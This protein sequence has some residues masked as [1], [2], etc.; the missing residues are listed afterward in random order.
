[1]VNA[2]D[3]RLPPPAPEGGYWYSR[4]LFERAL[5]LRPGLQRVQERVRAL[6]GP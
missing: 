2:A 5:A 4:W 3:D 1:M 6:K